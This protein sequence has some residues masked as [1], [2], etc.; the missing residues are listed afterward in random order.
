MTD[1]T[2]SLVE[3]RLVE[4]AEVL[5][6]LPP[7]RQQGFFNVWPDIAH[8]FADKVEQAP[9]PLRLPPPSPGAISRMDEALPWLSWLERTDARILWLRACG[10]RWKT[11]CRTVGLSRQAAH[12]HWL[13]GLCVISLK[14]NKRRVNPKASRQVMIAMGQSSQQSARE[15]KVSP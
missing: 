7:S 13:Y 8:E 4:A 11:V 6:R 3:E 2:P 14:L 1:W 12:Q 10:E 5:A 15:S 9:K